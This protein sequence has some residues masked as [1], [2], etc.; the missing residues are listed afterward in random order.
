M[1]EEEEGVGGGDCL[2]AIREEERRKQVIKPSKVKYCNII[3]LH[4][5]HILD[6]DVFDA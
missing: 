3:H 4:Q 2:S 6:I 5:L 1:K